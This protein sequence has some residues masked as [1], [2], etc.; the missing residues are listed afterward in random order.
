MGLWNAIPTKEIFLLSYV[1]TFQC[2]QD[3][4]GI[5]ENCYIPPAYASGGHNVGAPVKTDL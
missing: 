5:T 2:L 1:G 4:H 3:R